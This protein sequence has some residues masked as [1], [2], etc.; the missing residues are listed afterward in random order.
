MPFVR[1]YAARS[2]SDPRTYITDRERQTLIHAANGKTNASI[3][4]AMGVGQETVKTRMQ[5]I[6]RKLRVG[7]R[8]QA[9]AV[10][11]CL[12]LLEMDDVEIPA[13]AN[14]G[15]RDPIKP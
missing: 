5:S 6:L 2:W 8:T 12:G 10:A 15:Y 4:R 14:R 11:L 9:V 3:A 7:D 13:A 1:A